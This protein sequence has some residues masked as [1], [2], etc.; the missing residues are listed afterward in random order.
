MLLSCGRAAPSKGMTITSREFA[1]G[2]SIPAR[3]TC[4]GQNSPPPLA[5]KGVPARAKSLALILTDPDAP[6][7]T[8]THWLVW[9]IPA[10]SPTVAGMLG[11]NDFG[12]GAYGGPCPPN[13]EHRYVFTL[14]ALDSELTLPSTAKRAQVEQAMQGHVIGQ[15]T[16][17]GKYRKSL[18]R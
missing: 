10:S 8:F 11:I 2:Q 5:F 13:G 3:F 4:D 6:G 9:N 1:D 17:K 14:Y 12:N 18:I 15:A 7:G 16:L